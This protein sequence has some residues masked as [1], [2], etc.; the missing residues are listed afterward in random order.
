MFEEIQKKLKPFF[1]KEKEILFA[2]L[3]GSA[4]GKGFTSESDIDIGVYLGGKKVRDTFKRRLKLMGE[5][6]KILK[7]ESEVVILN[8]IKSVF[9]K[10][11]IIK[12]G[13]LLFERDRQKRI[14]FELETMR[15]YFDFLP[16]IEKYDEA[17]IKR[18]L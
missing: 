13:K 14:E 15:D 10:F 3:F 18:N 5:F 8:D 1:K 17:F 12:E 16:F 4:V 2:Y 7:R 6:E 11:V 9:F